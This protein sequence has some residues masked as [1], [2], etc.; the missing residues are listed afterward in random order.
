M[1]KLEISDKEHERQIQKITEKMRNKGLEGLYLSNPS[2]IFYLTGCT[3]IFITSMARPMGLLITVDEE[4]TLI[5]PE[6]E[7]NQV[8]DDPPNVVSDVIS[9][10][11]YPGTP[12]CLNTIAKV[13]EEKKLSNKTVGTDGP[14]LPSI[15][16]VYE[17]ESIQKKL[18][19]TKFVSGKNIIDEMRIQKS[20]E[21][22]EL[23]KEAAKWANLAHTYLQESEQPEM[24]VF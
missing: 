18:P 3:G 6:I 9:Y 12:H 4:L 24:Q 15:V 7:L 11:E 1:V 2:N 21:E 16:G 22:I 5:L 17:K 13:F 20:D 8:I 23:I 10:G 14:V 19:N